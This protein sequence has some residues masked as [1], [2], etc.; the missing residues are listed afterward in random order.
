AD[1]LLAPAP[2]QPTFTNRQITSFYFKPCLDA[3]GDLTGYY[4]CK[5][6]GKRRKH[7]PRT[8]YTNL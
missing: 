5:S 1:N 2:P 3:E 4:S 6:C 7:T 8:G